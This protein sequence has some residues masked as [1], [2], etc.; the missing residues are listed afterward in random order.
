MNKELKMN[1]EMN[2][3]MC[4]GKRKLKMNGE[5]NEEMCTGKRDND[6]NL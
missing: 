4:T 6:T 3:E 2:E 1:G 5:M